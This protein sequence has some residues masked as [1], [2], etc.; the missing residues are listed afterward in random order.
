MPRTPG[1]DLSDVIVNIESVVTDLSGIEGKLNYIKPTDTVR[2]SNN[3]EITGTAGAVL[4]TIRVFR[5]GWIRLK[6]QAKND[7]GAYA[8]SIRPVLKINNV[9]L[10]YDGV[11]S[12]SYQSYTVDIPIAA[13]DLVQLT[14]D[15]TAIA[16]Y[17]KNVEVCYDFATEE[18]EII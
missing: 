12:E 17:I 14:A 2:F 5:H 11:G 10:V 16:T 1:I 15:I 3:A 9:S 8:A 13:G 18:G 6:F 7:G 4:R